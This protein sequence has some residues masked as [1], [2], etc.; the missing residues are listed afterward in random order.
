MTPYIWTYFVNGDCDS[1]APAVD[2]EGIYVTK[3]NT[4]SK[5]VTDLSI[6]SDDENIKKYAV[7]NKKLWVTMNFFDDG[8]GPE[9][10][11][12]V[13]SKVE[14]SAQPARY[15]DK[16]ESF[17][18]IEQKLDLY[19]EGFS[20]FASTL[21][22]NNNHSNGCFVD[23]SQM[24]DL[25][26]GLCQIELIARDR[27]QNAYNSNPYYFIYDFT[28]PKRIPSPTQSS[29]NCGNAEIQIN[30][31][32][33]DGD[34]DWVK[35][36]E[37]KITGSESFIL[38]SVTP[39]SDGTYYTWT[40]N[41]TYTITA[42]DILGNETHKDYSYTINS[43][44]SV[45]NF[46]FS[47]GTWN[48]EITPVFENV[49]P[50]PVLLGIITD[51]PSINNVTIFYY[52]R[53]P[54]KYCIVPYPEYPPV[55][56]GG[57]TY[58]YN[59]EKD[60]ELNKVKNNENDDGLTVKNYYK[61]FDYIYY[62]GEKSVNCFGQN[63]NCKSLYYYIDHEF[64]Q[65]QGVNPPDWYLPSKNELLALAVD[66]DGNIKSEIITAVGKLNSNFLDNGSTEIPHCTNR[67]PNF[68]YYNRLVLGTNKITKGSDINCFDYLSSSKTTRPYDFVRDD[69][70]LTAHV[71]LSNH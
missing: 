59:Q 8:V 30:G 2:S 11:C 20:A 4:N 31:L 43:A 19:I 29:K 64:I 48:T 23:L 13:I 45:G 53:L 15:A 54:E 69:I 61:Q 58:Y 25:V 14:Q 68:Y 3:G 66:E 46:Y 1:D 24:P 7:R 9:S 57:T 6:F 50:A 70:C 38:N 18:P 42:S 56:S 65:G 41:V 49:T 62:S 5:L 34:L 35:F 32:T 12:A 39:S 17:E 21:E 44:P 37:T 10:L 67:G 28:A 51:V 60:L 52:Q 47:D 22:E 71:D 16:T 40:K 27:N 36:N 26:E 63:I 55:Q 33:D